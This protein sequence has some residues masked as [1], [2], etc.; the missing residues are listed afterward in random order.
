MN[1]IKEDLKELDSTIEQA[2]TTIAESEGAIKTLLARLK[3]EEDL[4]SE[5]VASKELEKLSKRITRSDNGIRKEYTE[6]RGKYTW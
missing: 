4:A 5:E 6:L 3:K 2:K 1:K